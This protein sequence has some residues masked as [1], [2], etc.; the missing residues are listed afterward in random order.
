MKRFRESAS[1]FL[2]GRKF[3]RARAALA[4]VMAAAVMFSV[5]GS[6]I[7]PA[8]SVTDPQSVTGTALRGAAS[9]VNAL[10]IGKVSSSTATGVYS[11]TAKVTDDK[12]ED[13]LKKYFASLVANFNLK[14]EDVALLGN[15]D[16]SISFN[17]GT[18][19][20]DAFDLADMEFSGSVYSSGT[21]KNVIGS[22]DFDP[23]TG[24]VVITFDF[25]A[26]YF[27]GREGEGISG[28]FEF[29]AWVWNEN[30]STEDRHLEIAGHSVDVPIY[31]YTHSPDLTVKKSYNGDFFY[32]TQG[33]QMQ[34]ERMLGS[35]FKINIKSINGVDGTTVSFT[36]TLKSD[37][38]HFD[39]TPGMNWSLYNPDGTPAQNVSLVID[40]IG[41]SGSDE[42]L[43]ARIVANDN[44]VLKE[45]FEY[46]W[47]CP[48]MVDSEYLTNGA[49]DTSKLQ[50]IEGENSITAKA[51]K[52]PSSS[53]ASEIQVNL[54]ADIHKN[55]GTYNP[56]DNT[57]S[58]SYTIYKDNGWWR[59]GKI[60]V[61]DKIGGENGSAPNIVPGSVTMQVVQQGHS[62]DDKEDP[63]AANGVHQISYDADAG[64][65][66]IEMD[67]D[68]DAYG[69]I[70][71][72]EIPIQEFI[73]TYKTYVD[74]D[75]YSSKIKNWIGLVDPDDPTKYND[76]DP[77]RFADIPKPSLAKDCT[78]TSDGITWQITV[79]NRLGQDLSGLVITDT[80]SYENTAITPPDFTSAAAQLT[81]KADGQTVSPSDVFSISG[82]KLTFK[83]DSGRLD[84][85]SY[86]IT[87]F[88][89]IENLSEYSGDSFN[90]DATLSNNNGEIAEA[91]KEAKIPEQ[92]EVAKQGRLEADGK[93]H[94]TVEF[95]NLWGSDINGETL[96]D[97]LTITKDGQPVD[98]SEFAVA[99]ES[100]TVPVIMNSSPSGN[101]IT[102]TFKINNSPT[103]ASVVVNYT[104]TP[105]G[106][107]FRTDFGYALSNTASWKDDSK[108]V[109]TTVERIVSLGNKSGYY[110]KETDTIRWTITVNNPYEVDLG[111]Y[112]TAA[113]AILED[114]QFGQGFI[115]S[116]TVK[117]ASGTDVTD[118]G[119]LAYVN[120]NNHFKFRSGMTSTSYTFEYTTRLKDV[121]PLTLDPSDNN[122][123]Y[124]ANN[125]ATY[126]GED[127]PAEV[128]VNPW[129]TYR[130]VNKQSSGYTA[131]EENG[132]FQISWNIGLDTYSGGF[133]DMMNDGTVI[134]DTGMTGVFHDAGTNEDT[135]SEDVAM[136]LTADQFDINKFHISFRNRYDW[137]PIGTDVEASD[138]FTLGGAVLDD[139]GNI[140]GFTLTFN[141]LTEGSDAYEALAS[142][143]GLTVSY[144]CTAEGG[145]L[146]R[147][148]D[149]NNGDSLVYRNTVSTPDTTTPQ[150]GTRTIVKQPAV[151]KSVYA[152]SQY[153]EHFE[154]RNGNIDAALSKLSKNAVGD[155][156]FNY[157]LQVN[158]YQNF[159]S[160]TDIVVTDELPPGMRIVSA[161]Y[162]VDNGG[163]NGNAEEGEPA[164]NKVTYQQT[165]NVLTITIPK[166]IHQGKG[167]DFDYITALSPD[168]MNAAL[169]YT[170]D[171]SENGQT[172]LSNTVTLGDD[173]ETVSLTV[174]D[175][176]DLITKSARQSTD[177]KGAL[178]T[179]A[180][181]YTLDI[182]PNARKLLTGDMSELNVRDTINLKEDGGTRYAEYPI[183]FNQL[184]SDSI[185]VYKVVGEENIA[186]TPEEFGLSVPKQETLPVYTSD[187]SDLGYGDVYTFELSIP[188]ETH[189]R[190]EYD[191]SFE[192]NEAA[193]SSA[194]FKDTDVKL[195]NYAVIDGKTSNT[196][197]TA[198]YDFKKN[199]SSAA[200][201]NTV[202]RLVLKKVSADNWMTQLKGA[203]FILQ[204]YSAAD[205][206]W[207][208]LTGLEEVSDLFSKTNL[209]PNLDTPLGSTQFGIWSADASES[210]I[211]E[212][213]ETGTIELPS[214]QTYKTEQVT[215]SSGSVSR[216]YYV[217]DT[218]MQGEQR[219][220]YRLTEL[221]APTGFY[222]ED[223]TKDYY[224]YEQPKDVEIDTARPDAALESL[225]L[226]ASK[227][228]MV[229]SDT[230][231]EIA[232]NAIELDVNKQ[233]LADD[234]GNRPES[235]SVQLYQSDTAPEAAKYHRVTVNI[236]SNGVT[237]SETFFAAD[238][239]RLTANIYYTAGQYYAGSIGA[240]SGCSAAYADTA[241]GLYRYTF[242]TTDPVTADSTFTLTF[243]QGSD[244]EYDSMAATSTVAQAGES[245]LPADAEA[246]GEP[247][248]L[249]AENGWKY[250][251]DTTELDST[252]YYYIEETVPEGYKVYYTANGFHTGEFG[253][254]N[255]SF[256][257]GNITL[258]KDWL[259][260]KDGNV[261]ELTFDIYG[262]YDKLAQDFGPYHFAKMPL[263][264]VTVTDTT[265]GSQNPW[266]TVTQYFRVEKDSVTAIKITGGNN[267]LQRYRMG[268]T[269]NG[270]SV[271][272][273]N[274][275]SDIT[276]GQTFN[277]TA[278][279]GNINS[280]NIIEV[281]VSYNQL[282][283]SGSFTVTALDSSQSQLTPVDPN[284]AV[285]EEYSEVSVNRPEGEAVVHKTVTVTKDEDWTATVRGLFTSYD[286]GEG[287]KP[288]YYYIV[289]RGGSG[290]V[291]IDYSANG[292]E[293]SKGKSTPV[294][295]TNR[296]DE[297]QSYQLPETGGTGTEYC[298]AAG[299]SI[300]F[301]AAFYLF[302]TR[303]KSKS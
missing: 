24:E 45:G 177:D 255:E 226:A 234:P 254:V 247:V 237:S 227:L 58:W 160:N 186:L 242:E 47:N 66:T 51:D 187:S 39:L 94:Y 129:D 270:N 183:I 7:R 71:Y 220:I 163:P 142:A 126:L 251:F 286:D 198:E 148:S 106:G 48:V 84:A 283:N 69:G 178:L 36:D 218:T 9:N 90:N 79:D 30:N 11:V 225:G 89:P 206:A 32:G 193:Q 102:T 128:K 42:V 265:Q 17:L 256:P 230:N 136:Y 179:N 154:Y 138:V 127:K 231:I 15:Y 219:Y 155:Y 274:D 291:P 188:D 199:Y 272:V 215:V 118:S 165:D 13:D 81:V 263:M 167:L 63:S 91:E 277:V 281:N 209:D 99:V 132:K 159:D 114:T 61:D 278:S 3:K 100:S 123:K 208:T 241:D 20:I 27:E 176:E 145:E 75:D 77:D 259:G 172:V 57:V 16:N 201:A 26:P 112:P 12:N 303:R 134:T 289:E 46:Y 276:N 297:T 168:D 221:K 92:F 23:T 56:E 169:A 62:P 1:D 107:D 204:R 50:I 175:D 53:S 49:V 147:S 68:D 82:N 85:E 195:K 19:N 133:I 33:A 116:F 152:K 74:P 151:S 76:I 78:V 158:K 200:H 185:R 60:Q 115:K 95:V 120:A 171:G 248:T 4:S 72:N 301:G 222:F 5:A 293:I 64:R 190:I 238:G 130:S 284:A 54:I 44:T 83:P 93:L 110:D 55:P 212:T 207:Q 162:S 28:G 257:V 236:Q 2:G 298:I 38:V 34:G 273:W 108:T 52:V 261:S 65:F 302:L 294:T 288:L 228:H 96:T 266:A 275:V 232:N 216:N 87:Y 300:I 260:D 139:D 97:V 181:T 131:P 80:L 197:H 262:Y 174:T 166:E 229:R 191:Y 156:V 113:Q 14:S 235:I 111:T 296:L 252:K 282:Y 141:T 88:Q 70:H 35:S 295:V 59:Y 18:E 299:A 109:N 279:D 192:F 210:Y 157:R 253:L 41:T 161:T 292:F 153:G 213:G 101:Q 137:H 280:D 287:E 223:G 196:S 217:Y 258:N 184:T 271:D 67:L 124:I 86:V 245:G 182:N 146:L 290:F 246:V 135:A 250:S 233:W 143:T 180:V 243:Y 249:T 122:R 43:T 203:Q 189:I 125:T 224:F 285:S 37:S 10:P 25:T 269:V 29:D 194:S 73:V 6:L 211:L 205:G 267:D 22:Y 119:D 244:C 170:G 173:F 121:A 164:S 117:D 140:I 240:S 144:N 239:Q 268:L 40:E 8:V 21:S 104:V 202:P 31:R 98:A 214:L 150:I 149:M 264:K 103:N 105:S